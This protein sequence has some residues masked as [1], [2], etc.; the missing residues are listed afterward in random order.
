MRSYFLVYEKKIKPDIQ[1]VSVK[2]EVKE[3][4]QTVKELKITIEAKEAQADYREVLAKFKKYVQ[5]P[6]FRKGKAPISKVEKMYG[7]YAKEQFYDDKLGKYYKAALD[8]I[9]ETPINAGEATDIKWEKGEDLVATF[10]FEVMPEIKV[11]KYKDLEI[12]FE[13]TEFKAEMVDG[14]IK[15]F[16][17]QMATTKEVEGEIAAGD[18]VKAKIGFIDED[19]KISKE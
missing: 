8:E 10:R 11:E 15:E 14:T 6:G 4:S 16:Q 9:D 19:G 1:G 2:H 13:P 7:D 18:I 17:E 3:I 12:P 5:I